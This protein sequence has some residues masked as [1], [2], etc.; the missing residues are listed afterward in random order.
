MQGPLHRNLNPFILATTG[1]VANS[2]ETVV[3]TNERGGGG[4]GGPCEIFCGVVVES[5][6]TGSYDI[7]VTDSLGTVIYSANTVGDAL[8]TPA[9]SVVIAQGPFSCQFSSATTAPTTTVYLFVRK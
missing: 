6:G 3:M 4:V 8:F 9:A 7:D 2:N 1:A 5:T